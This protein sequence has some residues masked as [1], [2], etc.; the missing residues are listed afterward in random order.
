MP[1]VTE[2]FVGNALGYVRMIRSGGLNHYSRAMKFIPDFNN[3]VGFTELVK[4]ANLPEE[5]QLAAK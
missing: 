1:F 5:T 3:E 4:Q 2:R